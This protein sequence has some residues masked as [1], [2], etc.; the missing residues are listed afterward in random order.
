ML[1]PAK[2]NDINKSN[3]VT[4]LDIIGIQ[5]HLLNR[6]TLNSPYKIIAAD[7]NSSNSVT[8]LDIIYVRRLIL[9]IDTTFPGN[10][11][12]S[13]VPSDY[14]FPNTIN[15]FPYPSTRSYTSLTTSTNQNFVGVK[16]GDVTWDWNPSQLKGGSVDSVI[17]YTEVVKESPTDTFKLPI[18]VLNFSGITGIQ[19]GLK[20]DPSLFELS[21]I[22]KNTLPLSFNLSNKSSGYATFIWNHPSNAGVNLIDSTL[23]FELTFIKKTNSASF[24]RLEL[25]NE[26]IPAEAYDADTNPFGVVYREFKKQLP[27]LVSV[28]SESIAIFPNPTSGL[29]VI[30]TDLTSVQQA[31]ITIQSSLGNKL[32][33][34]VN[35]FNKGVDR[36]YLDLSARIPGLKSG[37]YFVTVS[38]GGKLHAFKIVY[39][40]E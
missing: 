11:L 7:V 40:Q 38:L 4:T 2:N 6:D 36:V 8:T 10:K 24:P 13:F 14:T 3:G 34:F 16:L 37:I 12:W 30:R 27:Q 39:S 1:T 25:F 32:Y 33:T 19:F 20:W 35:T 28:A 9:G 15:P 5:K 26:K 18:K 22:S 31:V 23:I 17:L 21:L 29:L